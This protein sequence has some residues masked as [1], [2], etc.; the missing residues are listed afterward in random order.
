[1]RERENS[2]VYSL[3]AAVHFLETELNVVTHRAVNT[4]SAKPSST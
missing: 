2:P 4:V 1:M 3:G